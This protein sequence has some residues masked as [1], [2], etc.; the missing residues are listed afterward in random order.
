M[1]SLEPIQKTA[2]MILAELETAKVPEK[3]SRAA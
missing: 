3:V 1:V 2:S